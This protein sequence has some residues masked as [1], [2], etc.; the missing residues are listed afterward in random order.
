MLQAWN[1]LTGQSAPKEDPEGTAVDDDGTEDDTGLKDGRGD[2]AAS[3][4]AA[5]NGGERKSRFHMAALK[6]MKTDGPAGALRVRE[7][8]EIVRFDVIIRL[9]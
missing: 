3:A 1:Y 5:G 7:R 9:D 6:S 4:A 2:A 8:E